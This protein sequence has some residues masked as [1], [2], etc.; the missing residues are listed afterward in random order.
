MLFA[1]RAVR[2]SCKSRICSSHTV[3][4]PSSRAV[5]YSLGEGQTLAL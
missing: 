1:A 5:R 2:D 4:A 3:S